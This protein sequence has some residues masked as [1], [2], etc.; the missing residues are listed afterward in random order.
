MT[1]RLDRL[2]NTVAR[3]VQTVATQTAPSDKSDHLYETDFMAWCE[4]QA[5]ALRSQQYSR[6]DRPN[7]IEEIED[8]GREQFR[9]TTALVRQ[10]IIHILKLQAFPGDQ[11][12]RHWQS[13]IVA[14]QNDLEEVV[15][16]SVRYRFEQQEMFLVQQQKAIK[17]LQKEYPDVDFGPLASMNL[18]AIM[19]WPEA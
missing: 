10:I 2:E 12:S 18:D 5:A 7:L 15:T 19:A 16:G 17:Q 4:S 13:E 9:K 1:D 14:F 11:A 8:M 6:I 3:L